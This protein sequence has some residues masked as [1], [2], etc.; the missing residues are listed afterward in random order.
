MSSVNPRGVTFTVYTK[1][2]C[3]E[4]VQVKR[5]L[6]SKQITYTAVDISDDVKRQEFYDANPGVRSMPQ[7][8]IS[9][10]RVGGMAGVRQ[11][12][13]QIGGSLTA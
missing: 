1:E 8:F 7:V 12:L 13:A 9:G 5:L 10:Q 3:P 6:D 11:A 4:C 2:G